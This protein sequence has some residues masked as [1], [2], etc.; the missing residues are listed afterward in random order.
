MG[1]MN[2]TPSDRP[3]F[4]LSKTIWNSFGDF[5]AIF[6]FAILYAAIRAVTFPARILK[7]IRNR[8]P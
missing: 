8:R 1:D 5:D 6:A 7:R 4:V 3:E 2:T